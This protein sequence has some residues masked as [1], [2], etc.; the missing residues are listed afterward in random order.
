VLY[1]DG[2]SPEIELNMKYRC[3]ACGFNIF[4]RRIAKCESCRADL[5][6][7]LLFSPD[8][9]KKLDM[10][11]QQ[12]RKER[13]AMQPKRGHSSVGDIGQWVDDFVDGDYGGGCE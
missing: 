10:Q 1:D 2:F 13:E 3:P 8:E 9:I 12:R 4:N 7:H 6:A 5:P 11:Y